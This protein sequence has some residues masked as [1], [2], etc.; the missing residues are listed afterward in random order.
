MS[1]DF[2]V[3]TSALLDRIQQAWDSFQAYLATLTPEQLTVPTDRA[4]WS[5]K[6][7]V[8][9]VARWEEGMLA[10]LNSENRHEAMGVDEATW[11]GHD[12]DAINAVLFAR[13]KHLSLGDVLATSRDIHQRLVDRVAA[14]SDEEIALPYEH[15]QPGSDNETPVFAYIVGNTFEHYPDHQKWIDAL[16]RRAR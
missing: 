4:G 5:A 13:D 9:H 11:M 2:E 7:H 6:D 3:T 15:F 14:M 16:V 10:L 12:V 1:Y 8:I